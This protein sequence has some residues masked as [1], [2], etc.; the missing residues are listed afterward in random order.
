MQRGSVR[1]L[2]VCHKPL[3]HSLSRKKV[4]TRCVCHPT[5][6]LHN[7]NSTHQASHCLCRKMARTSPNPPKQNNPQTQSPL[8]MEQKPVQPKATSEFARAMRKLPLERLNFT[9]KNQDPGPKDEWWLEDAPATLQVNTFPFPNPSL[10]TPMPSPC[11]LPHPRR[12][13][14]RILTQKLK[15]IKLGPHLNLH[16]RHQPLPPLLRPTD[17]FRCV[18]SPAYRSP[19]AAADDEYVRDTESAAAGF[20]GGVSGGEVYDVSAGSSEERSKEDGRGGGGDGGDRWGRVG[21]GAGRRG[22]EPGG[23]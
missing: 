15:E 5:Y 10:M 17:R 12:Q 7:I 1:L 11:N 21:G 19:H 4:P 20:A 22:L 13:N 3:P 2:I 23:G 18:S 8:V 6:C 14:V 9:L 16:P